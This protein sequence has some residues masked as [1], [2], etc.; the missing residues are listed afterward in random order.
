MIAIVTDS[1]ACF[2][3]CEAEQQNIHIVPMTYTVNGHSFHE[4]Y[5][6]QNGQFERL[7]KSYKCTTSQPSSAAFMST[8]EELTR[9]GF[10]VLCL[11]ISSRL[12]GTYSS[13]LIA[14]REISRDKIR[15]VDTR[16]T[17]GGIKLL[18]ERAKNLID[19]GVT[20]EEAAVTL[21]KE[22]EKVTI[23]FS[24]ENMDS[25][26]K[27]G[28]IGYVRQSIGT[29]LNIRPILYCENGTIVSHGFAKGRGD[30]LQKLCG[31]IPAD[32]RSIIVNYIEDDLG[33]ANLSALIR[34]KFPGSEP[35]LC[36]AG[37]I[38]SIHVGI[39]AIGVAWT[40]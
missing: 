9:K 23:A 37:P 10:E 6:D 35:R 28:R 40:V 29:I 3:K 7:V 27:S 25:L 19:S 15:I 1:T 26:R 20:L 13:A 39:P 31:E 14:A 21:E 2:T 16:T 34:A 11:V 36:K 8:F 30:Q 12:S 38:L 33:A 22:R 24:V 32:A 4:C 17:S 5:I 18:C